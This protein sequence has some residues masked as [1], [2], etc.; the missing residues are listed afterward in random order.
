MT[1]VTDD[2]PGKGNNEQIDEKAL[3]KQLQQQHVANE[4]KKYDFPTEVIDL[5]S[6][7]LLYP[8]GHPLANGTIEMKYMTAKEEDILASANLIKQGVVIDKLLESMIV[9]PMD[10]KDLLVGD[11]NAIMIAARVLGYGKD[12][13]VEVTC[14]HCNEKNKVSV[15]LTDVADKEIDE[16]S[17]KPGQNIFDF[18][19]PQSGR[20]IQF[21]LMTH[22]LESDI[23]EELKGIKKL[24]AKTGINRELSTRL[25]YII[26]SVDGNT[27]RQAVRNFVDNELFAMDSRAFREH[28]QQ[29][30]P[31]V[32]LSFDF[33]CTECMEHN[34]KVDIPIDVNFFW[35][36]A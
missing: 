16:N 20:T 24:T 22:G 8:E 30:Q 6:K 11:K 10:Y 18:T 35:P 28:I 21:Q 31:D 4:V 23:N 3:I 2:L 13:N 19:L 25:K 27:D 1:Q 26:V 5:P 14:G 34:D 33:T 29:T 17:I 7:G 12:Y 9:T 32:D 15:D 36:G